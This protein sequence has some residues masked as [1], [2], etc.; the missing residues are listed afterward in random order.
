MLQSDVCCKGFY[1]FFPGCQLPYDFAMTFVVIV[2]FYV[3]TFHFFSSVIC[4]FVA[5]RFGVLFRKCL[6]ISMLQKI[7][8]TFL[9]N[10]SRF[11][12]STHLVFIR[13][14]SQMDT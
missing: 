8:Y 2:I 12:S 3:N 7:P 5:S 14:S 13:L 11:H 4:L 1:Q 6:L 10:I 9:A